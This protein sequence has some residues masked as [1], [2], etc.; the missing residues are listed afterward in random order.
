MALDA[1]GS[2]VAEIPPPLGMGTVVLEDGSEVCGFICEGIATQHALD[3]TAHGGWV[4]Y[5]AS[6]PR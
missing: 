6:R 3:I 5:L 2:F 4:A 1:F